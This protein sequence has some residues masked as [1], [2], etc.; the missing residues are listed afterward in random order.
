MVGTFILGHL[1][2]APTRAVAPIS[3][4]ATDRESLQVGTS[5]SHPL[6]RNGHTLVKL[7]GFAC[8]NAIHN[9]QRIKL[10]SKEWDNEG[11]G[12]LRTP[13]WTGYV[14]II[15]KGGRGSQDVR[16]RFLVGLWSR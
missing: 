11:N 16:H 12:C 10:R 9:P 2:P 8:I 3:R 5:T 14:G 4:I 6:S 7:G 15:R 13:A 1:E